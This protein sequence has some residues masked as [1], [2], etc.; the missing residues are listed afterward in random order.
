MNWKI[1]KDTLLENPTLNLQFE[2]ANNKRVDGSY[3]ITEIKQAQIVSVDCGGKMNSW[4][5]VILQLLEPELNSNQEAMQVNKALK[6]INT[7]EATLALHPNATTKIEFGNAVFE[8]RQM[9][10]AEI[11]KDGTN[12]VV[13]LSADKTQCKALDRGDSCGKPKLQI[14]E[15]T[16][17]EACCE[18]SSGCCS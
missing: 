11:T 3:H 9:L 12:L 14:A 4:N 15:L 10:I 1:F 8:T 18:P 2:Y 13:V 6:I 16:T 7:V 17:Q 5:E